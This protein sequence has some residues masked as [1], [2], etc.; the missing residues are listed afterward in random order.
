MSKPIKVNLVVSK[1]K[2]IKHLSVPGKIHW[3]TFRARWQSVL[4]NEIAKTMI[5]LDDTGDGALLKGF[6]D[7]VKQDLVKYQAAIAAGEIAKEKKED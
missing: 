6:I 1:P 3:G 2:D 7:V 4:D 5:W